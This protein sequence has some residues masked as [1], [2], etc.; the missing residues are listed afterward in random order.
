MSAVAEPRP[1]RADARANYE[2]L[3]AYARAAFA[4][5]GI[6]ASLED[7]ARRAGVGTGTL[8]RHFPSREALLEVLLHDRF[9]TLAARARE[10][11]ATAAP[12][13]ALTCWLREFVE[14]T[15]TYR[16]LTAAF[17]RTL[18]DTSTELH[19]ACEG[20]RE[21]GASLLTRAQRVGV[22][23]A[24]LDALELFTLVSGLAWS[25]EQTS[26]AV[27][28]R[29]TVDRLLTLALE[30]VAP[31]AL[32]DR[33]RGR[34]RGKADEPSERRSPHTSVSEQAK[35]GVDEGD[36]LITAGTEDLRGAD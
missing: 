3:L 10:L 16:G 5:H 32:P 13:F 28:G 14:F 35:P 25:Y 24:D 36:P 18:R 26:A 33:G 9:D 15:G 4:E 20:M 17:T 30:G 23:R 12:G 11:S 2:R 1:M 21:A 27:P 22:V 34:R 8:Y 19:T 29:V 7:I 6:G 31:T